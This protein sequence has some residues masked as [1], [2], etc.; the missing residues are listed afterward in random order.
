MAKFGTDELFHRVDEVLFYVWDPI[1][2]SD[3]PDA[4]HEYRSYVPAIWTLLQRDAQVEEIS[5]HLREI[6]RSQMELTPDN[7]RCDQAAA[8]LIRHRQ[9]IEEGCA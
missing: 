4:R 1:G 3:E 7:A 2:V 6:V 8:L 9:A 5:G